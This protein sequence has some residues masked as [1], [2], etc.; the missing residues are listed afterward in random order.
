MES[1]LDAIKRDLDEK[2]ADIDKVK[3]DIDIRRVQ[4]GCNVN[5]I[6][7]LADYTKLK[8]L[9]IEYSKIKR[10][11]DNSIIGQSK[12]AEVLAACRDTNLR[13]QTSIFSP[14]KELSIGNRPV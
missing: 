5:A 7:E 10:N 9:K 8:S 3:N 12:I 2:K 11:Y 14:V 6:E 13:P 1:Y 4:D